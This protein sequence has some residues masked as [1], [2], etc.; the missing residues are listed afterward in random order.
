MESW[1]SVW[2]R[3][4]VPQMCSDSLVA[5]AKALR[6]DDA[7][8][9]QGATTSPPP[10]IFVQDWPCEA[11]DV[12]TF[13]A[14]QTLGITTV[15]EVEEAFAQMCFQCDQII[16]E[17]AACRFFINWADETPRENMRRELLAEIELALSQRTA[18]EAA[19]S[20]SV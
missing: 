4:L 18:Q 20:N 3:G 8:L 14:W 7:R 13:G 19:K 10:L 6:E 5:L 11:C 17:L 15:A 16:G 1:R 12:I 2:R 9:I